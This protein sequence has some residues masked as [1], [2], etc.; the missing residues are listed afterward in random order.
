[1]SCLHSVVLMADDDILDAVITK[2]EN[3]LKGRIL[4]PKISGRIA[5]G[6]VRTLASICPDRS[7]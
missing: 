5:A 3:F 4:E 1:M 6:M 2:M 7:E